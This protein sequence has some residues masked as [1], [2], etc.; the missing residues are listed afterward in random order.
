[1]YV[2]ECADQTLY[3]GITNNLNRRLKQHNTGKGAVYTA[4]RR[5]VKLLAIWSFSDRSTALKAEYAF[6]QYPRHKKL[7][8]IDTK[9]PH[10]N[11]LF[12]EIR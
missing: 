8:L 11:G 10:Y 12:V 1:M 4:L 2:V 9:S 7:T 6:K 5:P 3:T